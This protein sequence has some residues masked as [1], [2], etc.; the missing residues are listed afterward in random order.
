MWRW[1]GVSPV[2]GSVIIRSKVGIILYL[3]HVGELAKT[4]KCTRESSFSGGGDG[5]K[6]YNLEDTRAGT[7]CTFTGRGSHDKKGRLAQALLV[8]GF[9]A[10]FVFSTGVTYFMAQTSSRPPL[11][12]SEGPAMPSVSMPGVSAPSGLHSQPLFAS[13]PAISPSSPAGQRVG[14]APR[15]P[16]RPQEA[17]AS[18]VGHSR[19]ARRPSGGPPQPPAASTNIG[20]TASPATLASPSRFHVQSG[21]FVNRD[22]AVSLMKRLR[23]HGY[24]VTL[25]EGQLYRVWVGRDL[26]RTEAERLAANLR[27]TG[28]D[29][30]LMPR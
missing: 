2:T 24:A 11:P 4:S 27:A 19:D 17:P 16:S 21:S 7:A 26:D 8:C 25:I 6:D 5:M 30:T 10:L 1:N 14:E 9:G 22:N 18:S 20:P 13:R 29:A 23:D 3:S 15:G 12:T 28:F